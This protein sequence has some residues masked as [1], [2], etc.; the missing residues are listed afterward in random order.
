MNEQAFAITIGGQTVYA[1]PAPEDQRQ[2]AELLGDRATIDLTPADDDL[3]GHAISDEI[4]VDVEGHALTLRLPNA[5]DAAALR[6]ALAVGAITA[7]IVG[8]GAIAALQNPAQ[9]AANTGQ[10]PAAYSQV[11]PA[12]AA[13][14]DAANALREQQFM[15]PQTQTV[16]PGT[17]VVAN[18]NAVPAQAAR[19][20]AASALR[21][22]QFMES[23]SQTVTPAADA[24]IDDAAPAQAQHADQAEAARE[25]LFTENR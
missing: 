9:P 17:N 1:T 7:T 8:A 10:I 25:Q 12:P 23:Q 15:E 18:A 19:A 24:T 14:A 22:Q 3:E 13:R 2:L 16:N 21:E 6:R 20:D 5:G 4:V 11:V